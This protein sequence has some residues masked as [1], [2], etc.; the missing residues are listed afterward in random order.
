MYSFW[1]E[2]DTGEYLQW[3]GLT[4]TVA[5]R[6]YATTN[7]S[8]PDNLRRWGWEDHTEG[9]A[10]PVDQNNIGEGKLQD[11]YNNYV[12]CVGKD[13]AKTFDEWLNT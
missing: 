7:K 4:K 10:E 2:T 1:I 3:R 9:Y 8:T 12:A 13:N 11:R 5:Q 6:M